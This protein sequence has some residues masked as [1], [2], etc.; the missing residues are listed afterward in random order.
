MA[1]S[2][3]TFGNIERPKMWHRQLQMV[4][5]AKVTCKRSGNK[6]PSFY[7]HCPL[8]STPGAFTVTPVPMGPQTCWKSCGTLPWRSW[9]FVIAGKFRPLRGSE[10]PVARG[11]RWAVQTAFPRRS[12]QEL[13]LEAQP[14][15]SFCRVRLV[16]SFCIRFW[17][18]K[19]AMGRN[20][21]VL[22]YV[23]FTLYGFIRT[24]LEKA[25]V[26][27]V[28]HCPVDGVQTLFGWKS[29]KL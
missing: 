3:T 5:H 4:G 23:I 13:F 10:F 7:P 19:W 2:L 28:C 6:L 1:V 20:L 15:G 16:L 14:D 26:A 27:I 12:C 18:D 11:Q 8:L 24:Q 25:F 21:I 22:G 17:E 9:T 29:F